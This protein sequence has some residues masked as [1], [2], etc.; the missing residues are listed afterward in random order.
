[1]ET[2]NNNSVALRTPAQEVLVVKILQSGKILDKEYQQIRKIWE[3]QVVSS[4]DAAIFIEYVL[5]TL[6][7]RRYFLN[8]R[9]RAF[10][11][12]RFCGT[13]DNIIRINQ[14]GG[15]IREWSCE[16]CFLNSDGFKYVA[17]PID[18]QDEIQKY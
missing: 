16:T 2:E 18:K 10:K 7:F 8:G 11:Q 15:D 13:R 9:H 3:H 17:V 1:M 6:R 14:I 4:K 12:C 5:S